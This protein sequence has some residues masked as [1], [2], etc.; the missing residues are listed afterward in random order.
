M[1]M[2][3]RDAILNRMPEDGMKSKAGRS[4]T[5]CF[6]IAR[7]S[8]LCFSSL[9]ACNWFF[10]IRSCQWSDF[11]YWS[12]PGLFCPQVACLRFLSYGNPP[13]F[14][15]PVVYS[16]QILVPSWC[17]AIVL[18]FP[19]Y[20]LCY[21]KQYPFVFVNVWWFAKVVLLCNDSL[22]RWFSSS[23]FALAALS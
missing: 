15:A 14:S 7:R 12:L 1:R 21:C 22:G 6:R 11:I 20:C 18:R 16:I 4:E 9:F 17:G 19:H 8:W 23:I 5:S 13:I 10:H 2:E 3:P